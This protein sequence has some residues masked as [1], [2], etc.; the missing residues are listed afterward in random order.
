MIQDYMG[1]KKIPQLKKHRNE[2]AIE[3]LRRVKSLDSSKKGP[4]K[5]QLYKNK[6][7]QKEGKKIKSKTN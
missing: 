2:E 1:Q 4:K 7:K 5:L 3:R 6:T